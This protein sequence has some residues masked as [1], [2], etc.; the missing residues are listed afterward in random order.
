MCKKPINYANTVIYRICCNDPEVKETYVGSTTNLTKRRQL[1]KYSCNNP[2]TKEYATSKYVFIRAHGGFAEWSV[3]LV[4]AYA[5]TDHEDARRRE[6][7]W[8]EY[9]TAKLNMIKPYVSKC[10]VKQSVRANYIEN[11]KKISEWQANYRIENTE[12]F[13]E[14]RAANKER[15]SKNDKE[16][17]LANKERF[18]EQRA[19][20]YAENKEQVAAKAREY[21]IANNEHVTARDR[22]YYAANKLKKQNALKM[23]PL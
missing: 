22:A 16:Y 15:I 11:K 4:E 12:Q 5:A 20:K 18:I 14:Y 9:Y 7:H 17:R 10:E 2:K 23:D 6:R 21:R 3:I 8:M 13:V 1:H 19:K